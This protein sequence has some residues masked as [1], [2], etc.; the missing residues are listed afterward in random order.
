M[1]AF[2]PKQFDPFSRQAGVSVL[3][4]CVH[5]PDLPALCSRLG[6]LYVTWLSLR[7]SVFL[8]KFAPFLGNG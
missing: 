1:S 8:I 5:N 6:V 2:D 4:A 3:T 7:E